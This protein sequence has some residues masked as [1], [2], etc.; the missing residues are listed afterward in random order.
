MRHLRKV[1]SAL[2]IVSLA[3]ML[4]ACT[5]DQLKQVTKDLS[6]IATAVG[7]VQAN[8]IVAN[9][10]Q[11][12]DDKTTGT[13]LYICTRVSAAGKQA[14]AIV[15]SITKLDPASRSSLVNLLTPISQALDPTQLEFVAGIKDLKTKQQVDGAFIL[16]RSTISGMQLVLAASK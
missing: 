3:L 10:Q 4:S 12:L 7:E 16:L 15:R 9:Q 2:L 13:I 6:V 11:L 14:D 8:V 5:D 1:P